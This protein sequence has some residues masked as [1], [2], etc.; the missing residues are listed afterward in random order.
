M[1][2]SDEEVMGVGDPEDVARGGQSIADA[3]L[4]EVVS[5]KEAAPLSLRARRV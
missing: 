5:G 2:P 1:A 4:V 3:Q